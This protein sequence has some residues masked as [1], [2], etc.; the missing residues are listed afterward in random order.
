MGFLDNV[1]SAVNRGT[2][3]AGRGADKI[4][5]NA[6]IC[7]L[8]RQRQN[9]AAQLG[10]SLYEARGATRHSRPVARHS[11]TASPASTPSARSAS[12]RLRP[13]T[14]RPRLRRPPPRALPVRCAGRT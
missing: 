1:T 14:S 4:K 2:A 9:L 7:E 13:S 6:R 12:G 3:A 8:N 5:L 10:A 11:T